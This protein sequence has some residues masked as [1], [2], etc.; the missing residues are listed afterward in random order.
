MLTAFLFALTFVVGLA[1]WKGGAPERCGALVFVLMALL[2]YTGRLFFERVF[3][4]VDPLAVTVD[5]VALSGFTLIALQANRTW[6]FFIAAMQLLSCASHF[7]RDISSKVEPLVYA[8]LAY[9][10]TTA[11]IAV[12]LI[13]VLAH[14][15]RVR[16]GFIIPGWTTGTTFPAWVPRA[17]T[18]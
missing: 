16:R 2:Q 13:G 4:A 11:A 8:L 12:L 18:Q 15:A 14:L 9:G 6:P 17:L 7:G 3:D 10:P 5:V 1:L